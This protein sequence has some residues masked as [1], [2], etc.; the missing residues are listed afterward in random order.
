MVDISRLTAGVSLPTEVASEIM[1]LTTSASAVASAAR[2][3][4]LP[5]PGASVPVFT[6]NAS[7]DWVA[8]TD[9]I[10]VSNP[11]L[12]IKTMG[13]YKLATIVPFSREFV[14]DAGS[15]YDA[16]VAYLPSALALKIDQTVAG[17]SAPGANF[18]VLG[19]ATGMVVDGTDTGADVIAII[20]ALAAMDVE[21]S[22]IIASPKL[23]AALLTALDGQGRGLFNPAMDSQ[24]V[25]SVFGA[26]VLRVRQ[27]LVSGVPNTIGLVGDF[28]SNATFGSVNGVELKVSDQAT[29]GTVNLFEQD[30]IAVRAVIEV[31]FVVSD[32]TKFLKVT[33]A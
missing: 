24:S 11:S 19:G 16:A 32:A 30:M 17:S 28:A 5:G 14:R 13:A 9:A 20:N 1:G 15:L 2:N 8:E 25:G 4:Q 3:I 7:A 18:S 12:D 31:G 27:N 10:G 23:H 22:D 26:D 29:V 21:A 6:G 33:D